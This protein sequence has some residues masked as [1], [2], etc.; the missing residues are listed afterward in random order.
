MP[1]KESQIGNNS[2][3]CGGGPI[4]VRGLG[5]ASALDIYCF[6]RA[7][8]IYNIVATIKDGIMHEAR[9]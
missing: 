1:D 8:G 7:D 2:L 3:G 5:C 4:R 9:G 6:G